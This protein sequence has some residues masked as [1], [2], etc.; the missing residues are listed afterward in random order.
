V[1]GT[2]TGRRGS[3]PWRLLR[4]AVVVVVVLALLLFA[5]GGWYY[6]GR[7]RAG[8]LDSKAPGTPSLQTEILAAGDHSITLARDPASPQQ[9]TTPGTWGLRWAAGYGQLG[10]IR[11]L[12]ADRV[13]RVFTR[14]EGRPPRAGERSAVEGYAW[15]ADPALAAGRPAAEVRYPSP[16]GPAP[17]WLVDGRRDTWVILVHGYNAARTETLRTLATVARQGFPALAISYR[18]DPG[19][20]RTSDGLRRWGATEWRDLEAATRYA[21][22]R[23]ATS[24][25]LAGF[26]M[27]GAVVTSFLLSSPL[28]ARVRGVVLDA[29]ALDLGEVIDHGSA[30]TELPVVGTPVP[31]ALTVVAKG[32]AGVRYDLDWGQL[33]YVD[34]AGRL[35]APMLVFHQSGD[36]TVPVTISEALAAARSDLVTFERFGGDGHVQA[37]NVDRLRYE[38]ALRAFLDR[39]APPAAAA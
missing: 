22:D 5:G 39:V 19:A 38:R 8:A 25:V 2:V 12:G 17:A 34:R 11:S 32:I 3:R 35:A 28:A 30:D 1:V 13:E 27:G 26:S 18:N 15:P 29:P 33:D 10:A 20:P 6:S 16:L 9:L 31:P 21:L 36:P 14:L 23:G 24:V 7:I 4:G 37:W